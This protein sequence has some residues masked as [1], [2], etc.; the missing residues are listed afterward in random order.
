MGE[1]V[2]TEKRGDGLGENL[3]LRIPS[4]SGI[5]SLP[6]LLLVN[7][8]GLSVNVDFTNVGY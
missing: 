3:Y 4:S 5:C 1:L 2:D 7:C 6:T 8:D